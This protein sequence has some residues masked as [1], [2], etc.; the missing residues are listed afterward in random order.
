MPPA[1]DAPPAPSM[2]HTGGWK[3]S[4]YTPEMGWVILQRIA[5]GET[6]KQIAADPAMPSYATIFHWRRVHEDFA[7]QWEAVRMSLAYLRV[8]AVKATARAKAVLP[9]GAWRRGRK[10]S[11]TVERGEAVCAL[12]RQGE[13][14]SAINAR[15]EMPS[16]R[17]VYRWLKTEPVFRRMVAEARSE[18][19]DWLDFLRREAAFAGMKAALSDLHACPGHRAQVEYLDGRIGRLTPKVYGRFRIDPDP[20]GD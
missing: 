1:S 16:A 2:D 17:V 3:D 18:G 4:Q 8:E 20:P 19:L 11:F 10:S 5:A 7:Y 14:M 13:A 12:L 15:P 6:V 9:P